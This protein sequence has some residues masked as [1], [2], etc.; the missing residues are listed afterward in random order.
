MNT[1]VPSLADDK[2]YVSHHNSKIHFLG[3]LDV[4][5]KKRRAGFLRE[6]NV[7]EYGVL[8]FVGAVCSLSPNYVYRA[9]KAGSA[10]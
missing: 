6:G 8:A 4:V 10:N 9:S 2:M 1:M 3:S 7:K 5:K